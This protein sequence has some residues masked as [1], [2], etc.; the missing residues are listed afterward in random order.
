MG[1][2]KSEKSETDRSS[3]SEEGAP[4][5]A[6]TGPGEGT[7]SLVGPEM[8]IQGDVATGGSIRIDGRVDGAVDAGQSVVIGQDG[9]VDGDLSASDA[10]IAGQVTGAV[11]T[12]NRAEL[13]PTARVEG[14][15]R[16]QRLQLE[17]GAVLNGSVVVGELTVEVAASDRTGEEQGEGLDGGR[18]DG[19]GSDTE[20]PGADGHGSSG[21]GD[22]ESALNAG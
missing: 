15:L 1:W 20:A 18:G 5:R 9:M 7:V 14:E 11:T 4:S 12:G 2:G 13:Q 3:G 6:A 16:T 22:E 17:D 21:G 8:R 10:V 19:N